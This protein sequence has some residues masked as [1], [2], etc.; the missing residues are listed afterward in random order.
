MK[1]LILVTLV[2]LGTLV[3]CN[4]GPGKVETTPVDSTSVP[5]DTSVVDSTLT[6][7]LNQ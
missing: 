5:V 2:A 3:G 4:P 7:T 6:D 1:A